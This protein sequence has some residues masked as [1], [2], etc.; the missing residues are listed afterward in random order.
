MKITVLL[1]RIVIA[2][3]LIALAYGEEQVCDVRADYA[4]GFQNYA[5]AIRL[6]EDF[7]ASHPDDALAHYHLGFA[8][9]VTGRRT[10]ELREYHKAVA[11]KLDQWDLF[12]NLALADLEGGDL[13]KAIDA[14]RTAAK[15]G[16]DHEEAPFDLA[17][18]YQQADRLPEALQ[19]ISTALFLEPKDPEAR[20]MQA[21]IYAELGDLHLAREEWIYLTR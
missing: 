4:L 15:L 2:N 11:L 12:L 1:I 18:A 21:V 17:L 3:G 16:P 10:K 20:N 7:L 8:Y 6:H 13:G 14:L 19:E 9:S 5:E